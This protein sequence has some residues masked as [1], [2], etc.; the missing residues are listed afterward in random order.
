MRKLVR[1]AFK[2]RMRGRTDY[3]KRLSLLKSGKPRLVVRKSNAKL[4]VQVV[5]YHPDGDLVMAGADSSSLANLGWKGS[6]KSIP[7]AYL[8]GFLTGVRALEKGVKEAVLDIGLHPPVKG[9]RL[10][11]AAKGALDAGLSIPCSEEAFPSEERIAGKHLK[12]AG[13]VE[14]VKEKIVKQSRIAKPKPSKA[15]EGLI[16]DEGLGG[17]V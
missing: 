13:D 11:A 16:A 9:S 7:A 4:T 17:G 1:L 8:V 15:R 2:R 5:N 10:F 3:K 12:K 6:L 14:A